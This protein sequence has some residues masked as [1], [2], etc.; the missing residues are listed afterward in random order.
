MIEIRQGGLDDPRVAALVR[1][2]VAAGRANT[3]PGSAHALD[4]S[5]LSAPD[6]RFWSAWD[7]DTLMGTGALKIM[8]PDH[9]EVKSMH[10]DEAAR[11]RGV[12]LAMLDRIVAEAHALGLSRLSLET[13]SWDYF[14]PARAFYE[15]FGFVACPPFGG[16]RADPNSVFYTL[17]LRR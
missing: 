7:G 9:G 12:G 5:G 8:A 16:Y 10:T 3:E 17:D 11:R 13:G 15:R 1:H 6:I 4:I 2:H 14:I